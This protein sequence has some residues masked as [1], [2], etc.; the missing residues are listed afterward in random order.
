MNLLSF[1]DNILLRHVSNKWQ[2]TTVNNPFLRTKFD[3]ADMEQEN[4]IIHNYI[5]MFLHVT[6][7]CCFHWSSYVVC[8]KVN[9]PFDPI[10][11]LFGNVDNKA[12]KQRK[13]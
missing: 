12:S 8:H 6:W 5:V 1:S 2:I 13:E 10:T 11:H 4:S 7:L 3:H 9:I